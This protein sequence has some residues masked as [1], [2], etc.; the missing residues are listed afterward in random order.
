MKQKSK[1]LYFIIT[2]FILTSYSVVQANSGQSAKHASQ[3]SG[4]GSQ[5]ALH[6][7]KG[8]GKVVSGTVAVPLS[9]AGASGATSSQVADELKQASESPIGKPLE[10]TDE[11]IT[12]GPPPDQQLKE[13]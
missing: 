10:I 7:I 8:T 13:D 2:L 9:A 3:A 12:I 4:H 6:A 5:S 11:T 1:V